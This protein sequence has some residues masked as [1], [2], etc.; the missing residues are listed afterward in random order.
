MQPLILTSRICNI[1]CG[2]DASDQV[3]A[4]AGVQLFSIEKNSHSYPVSPTEI[5]RM[6]P[7]PDRI[8]AMLDHLR[9]RRGFEASHRLS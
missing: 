1:L 3:S 7:A 9:S 2:N 6:R 5:A 4:L 8:D